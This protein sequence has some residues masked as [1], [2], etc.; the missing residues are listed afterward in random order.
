MI[1]ISVGVICFFFS[2]REKK[3]VISIPIG[4]H[5]FSS[6]AGRRK[7]AVGARKKKATLE[8]PFQENV[9]VLS[10]NNLLLHNTKF[11]LT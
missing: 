2:R 6:P 7:I 4:V 11:V 5:V 8:W 1:S 10:N 3:D 9:I